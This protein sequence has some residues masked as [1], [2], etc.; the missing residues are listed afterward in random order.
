M[1]DPAD[2][3]LMD[4]EA[5]GNLSLAETVGKQTADLIDSV[6]GEFGEAMAYAFAMD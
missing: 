1:S 5:G 2:L 6:I 4:P 3:T